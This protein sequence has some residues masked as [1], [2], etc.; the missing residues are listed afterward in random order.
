MKAR[1]IEFFIERVF[2]N[3]IKLN[4]IFQFLL[5]LLKIRTNP[6]EVALE[7]EEINRESYF[8]KENKSLGLQPEKS[9]PVGLLALFSPPY[10]KATF[11][12][13]SIQIAQQW[14]GINAILF[15]SGQMFV[16]A[17]V[18]PSLIQYAI[19]A[20]G[21]VFVISTMSTVCT[22]NGHSIDWKYPVD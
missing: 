4:Y 19:C 9:S 2:Y 7:M 17:Q 13:C 21:I 3:P 6:E 16:R 20:T 10:R 22:S 5:D 11:L 8:S 1:L 18:P 15:Y 12:S 14:S